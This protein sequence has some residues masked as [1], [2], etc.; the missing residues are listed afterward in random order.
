MKATR[1]WQSTVGRKVIMAV[2][3]LLLTAF[4][5]SHLAANLLLFLPDGG[6][7]YN[8]YSYK[9]HQLQPW[10]NLARAA[11]L[12]FF[13]SHVV[14]G[15]KVSLTNRR[16]RKSR[17]AVQA[18]KGG[19]SKLTAASRSMIVSGLVLL[20]FVPIHVFMFSMGPYYPTVIDGQPMR[21]LYQLVIEKFN[22]PGVALGYAATML[23][24]GAHLRHG[25]WSALQSLAAMSRRWSPV[26]YSFGLVFAVLLAGGFVILPLYVLAFVPV[27]QAVA[28]GGG[29]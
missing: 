20:V 29:L 5:I 27:P 26:V 1:T 12:I 24:L 23:I 9:L 18:T 25:F 4:L 11:L 8:L 17:Y 10:L 22:M 21:D 14:S 19:P 16:A 6:R 7:T 3:G 15:I 2:T 28:M 13:L